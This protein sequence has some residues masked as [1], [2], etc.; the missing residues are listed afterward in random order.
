MYDSLFETFEINGLT[1]KN[2]LTMAPLYLGY[3]GE[4]GSIST[5]LLEHYRLMARSVLTGQHL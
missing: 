4:G 1:L 5:L 3:A 2:R